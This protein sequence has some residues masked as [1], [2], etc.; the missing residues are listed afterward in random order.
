MP[1]YSNDLEPISQRRGKNKRKSK[2]KT[3]SIILVGVVLLYLSAAIFVSV[4]SNLSTTIAQNGIVRESIRTTGYV[5]REQTVITAPDFGYL[6][7]V[8][9]EGER[10]KEGQVVGYIFGTSTDAAVMEEI[11]E[12][13]RAL[14]R[15]GIDE[16]ISVYSSMP[17]TAEKRISELSRNLSDMRKTN[18][19]TKVG[20][21]KEEINTLVLRKHNDAGETEA[22]VTVDQINSRLNSLLAS[23]QAGG[24]VI[25]PCG[26]VFTT[27][28][29]G[30]EDKLK[31]ELSEQ[32]TPSY[33]KS[34]GKSEENNENKTAEAG[35]P[36]CKIVNNY[37]W[38]FAM[39]LSAEKAENI[40]L[41]QSVQ[42]EFF[43]LSEETIMGTVTRI[44]DAEDGKCAIVV[45]TNKYVE[46]IYSSSRINADVITT[47]SEGIKLPTQCLHVKDG[48]TGVYV[49]RLDVA[50]FVPVNVKY[51]NDQW[52]IIS[53]AEPQSG[54]AR[55]QIYDEVIV[56]C[57]NLEDGKIIR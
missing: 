37:V 53:A 10:V 50:R 18:D 38:R 54:G 33:L 1:K 47:S 45:S 24:A 49:I 57:R 20:D 13:H 43:D 42:L 27:R 28:V 12:L 36:L 22:P 3:A 39:E 6:E 23:V 34:I 31:Y 51:K 15:V 26:G 32:V 2:I 46:G 9:N 48:V 4:S 5:F 41:G 19:L 21:K 29:D 30:L 16:E 55:L 52:A 17:A 40:K 44:S 11:K 8:V 14:G 56:D 35:Q 7:C 25:A